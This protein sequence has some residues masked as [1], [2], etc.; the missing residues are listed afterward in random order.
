MNWKIRLK[1]GAFWM[2]I[3]SILGLVIQY[4]CGQLG[5][6]FDWEPLNVMLTGVLTVLVSIGILSDTSTP[7]VADSKV[8]MLKTDI[9]DKA[10]AV[11]ARNYSNADLADIL[12]KTADKVAERQG[13]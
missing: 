2:G 13:K 7:G 8:T 6:A 11:V 10:E 3:V 9:N 1:S 4:A 12:A 5:L